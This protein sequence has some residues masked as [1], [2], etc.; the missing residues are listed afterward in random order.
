MR[1]PKLNINASNDWKGDLTICIRA[2]RRLA[3]FCAAVL[4]VT[5]AFLPVYRTASAGSQPYDV[6]SAEDWQIA[7]Q[8][9]FV[10]IIVL[11]R[12]IR[13]TDIPNRKITVISDF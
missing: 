9:P 11:H 1:L 7:V 8:D 3:F 6:Y 5:A 13:I 10:D 12:D 4:A 2:M